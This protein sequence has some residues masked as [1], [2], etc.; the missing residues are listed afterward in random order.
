MALL[1]SFTAPKWQ[2]KNP[3]VRR[4][5][6]SQLDDAAILLELV[7]NDPDPGVRAAALARITQP[8]TLDGLID[9]LTHALQA[10]ARE[11]RLRQILPD[12]GQLDGIDDD[13]LLV[14]IASLAEDAE[15]VNAAIRRISSETVLAGLAGSHPQARVRMAAAQN[16]TSLQVINELMQQTR[17]RD[18]SLYRHCK[19]IIDEHHA[20]QQ[21]D[22]QRQRQIQQLLLQ[23]GQLEHCASLAEFDSL[24]QLVSH[25]VEKLRCWLSPEQQQAFEQHFA[26]GA[27][28]RA[29]LAQRRDAEQQARAAASAA[30]ESYTAIMAEL[31]SLA[32]ERPLQQTDP[33]PALAALQAIESR[34]Q[35]A[36]TDPPPAAA[37]DARYHRILTAE[38]DRLLAAQRLLGSVPRLETLLHAAQVTDHNDYDGLQAAHAKTRQFLDRLVLP[39]KFSGAAVDLVSQLHLADGGLTAALEALQNSQEKRIDMTRK[40]LAALQSA[41]EQNHIRQADQSLARARNALRSLAPRCRERFEHELR[42]LT[43][44]LK[45]MH[46]WQGFAVEPKKVELCTRMA[47]LIDSELDPDSLAARIKDLQEQWRLLGALPHSREHALWLEFKALADQAWQPCQQ[48]FEQRAEVL[49]Q[50]R[51][52][53]MQ[54]VSQLRDYERKMCWPDA[55]SGAATPPPAADATAPDWRMVQKTLDTARAAFQAIQP[56]TVKAE[57]RSHQ[58]LQAVCDRIYAHIKAEYGRN[59]A[60]KQALV[61]HAGELATMED[62]PQAI[63]QAKQLQVRWKAIGITPVAIDRKLWKAFRSAC[64]A[65]FA[66]LDEQRGQLQAELSAQVK[67]AESLVQQ[68]RALLPADDEHIPGL[69]KILSELKQQLD[70]LELP[71][72]VQQ[73]I[74]GEF[75]N[76]QREA[77]R[78]AAELRQRQ[79]NQSWEQLRSAI[80]RCAAGPAAPDRDGEAWSDAPI[81]PRGLNARVLQAFWHT[82]PAANPDEVLRQA[83]I[84]LEVLAGVESPE[85]DKPARM[86]FQMQRLAK[87]LGGPPVDPEQAL[88]DIIH[89]FIELRPTAAWVARFCATLKNMK[90]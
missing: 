8:D 68:A 62:L 64:D 45:E 50:N 63:E 35:A 67:H 81:L 51:A 70:P 26:S 43:A 30:N 56:L 1:S 23:A 16:I 52:R 34:W 87:G 89:G 47:S 55:A 76:L 88:L 61:E 82:G 49:R 59:I 6:I 85:A 13:A 28:C 79:Q 60:S 58:A 4:E 53:R 2:H 83:C 86:A 57:R 36:Q 77:S 19:A 31:E 72:P 46:D 71:R 9:S 75:R 11:Q 7:T 25:Q 14:R 66:R 24:Q 41:L 84:A 73:R 80:T 18:K 32:A 38:R 90:G 69:G 21:L 27:G 44:R 5:G 10:Q 54:I 74:Q 65:V 20:R 29:Q 48:A 33:A 39:E 40:A 37:L 12:V 17:G 42:P 3:D 22:A 78:V 15:L